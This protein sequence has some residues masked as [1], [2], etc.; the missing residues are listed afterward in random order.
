MPFILMKKEIFL[1]SMSI[2]WLF[3]GGG[4]QTKSLSWM[5]VRTLERVTFREVVRI[6]AFPD[7]LLLSF[8]WVI[9]P[10]RRAISFGRPLS[11]II[12]REERRTMT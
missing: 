11:Q 2:R 7:Y 4:Y 5:A 8:S 10:S 9:V 1:R 6:S 12:L 3:I